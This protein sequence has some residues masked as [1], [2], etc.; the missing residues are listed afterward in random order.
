MIVILFMFF[1]IYTI[2]LLTRLFNF[3][4]LLFK[5]YFIFL[6]GLLLFVFGLNNN[7]NE[8]EKIK[9]IEKKEKEFFES[10]IFIF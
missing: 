10:N 5:K 8:K 7:S 2:Q 4:V 1:G 3:M 9:E 6:F